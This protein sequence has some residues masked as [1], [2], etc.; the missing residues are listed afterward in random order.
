MEKAQ[1]IL[2]AVKNG[3]QVICSNRPDPKKNVLNEE[4]LI[5]FIEAIKK[6]K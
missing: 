6:E 2:L 4:T 3:I 5:K 1:A